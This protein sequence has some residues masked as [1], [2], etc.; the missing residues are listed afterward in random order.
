MEQWGKDMALCQ[1]RIDF[2]IENPF[3]MLHL[4]FRPSSWKKIA[5]RTS[6]SGNK[7]DQNCEKISI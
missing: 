4:A 5:E 1:K 2:D 7:T 6:Q 3:E